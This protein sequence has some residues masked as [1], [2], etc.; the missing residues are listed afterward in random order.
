MPPAASRVAAGGKGTSMRTL[1][2]G[3]GSLGLVVFLL[4]PGRRA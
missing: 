4:T 1:A 3:I 2:S